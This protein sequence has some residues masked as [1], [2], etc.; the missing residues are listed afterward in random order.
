MAT[1]HPVFVGGSGR[2]GTTI[3]GAVISCHPR[4]RELPFEIKVHLTAGAVAVGAQTP[5]KLREHVWSRHERNLHRI[6]SREQMASLLDDFCADPADPMRARAFIEGIMQPVAAEAGKPSW[7]EMTPLNAMWASWL[8]QVFPDMKL[9]HMI[10][11]GRDVAAS[12]HA[13]WGEMSIPEALDWWSRRIK[14]VAAN[15]EQLPPERVLTVQFEDLANLQREATYT[16]LLEFLDVDDDPSIRTF[17][18]KRLRP[19]KAH[20]SRWKTDLPAEERAALNRR[21]RAIL[22]DFERSGVPWTPRLRDIA[23]RSGRETRTKA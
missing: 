10:R 2:S 5:D 13:A 4:F 6:I 12:T 17:F 11:D 3:A 20:I 9:V 16:R 15:V 8:Y 21:Y 22:Q 7:V 18:E 1:V 23:G 19:A 14:Q